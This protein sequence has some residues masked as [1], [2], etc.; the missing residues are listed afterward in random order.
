VT[1]AY[2]RLVDALGDRVGQA[3]GTKARARCP[4]HDGQSKTSLAITAIEG[5]VLLYCHAGCSTDDV[6]AALNFTKADLFDNPRG[7]TFTY[8]NGRTVKRYHRNGTKQFT[9]A[10]TAAAPEL[11]RLAKVKEAVADHR[12]VFVVEGEKDVHALESVGVVATCN[13]MGAGKWDKVDPSPLYGGKILVIAD[14]DE[15]GRRHACDV[16]A[17]LAGKAAAGIFNPATGCHDASDHI[18][19]GYGVG[20]FIPAGSASDDLPPLVRLDE[21]LAA[22]DDDLA[23]RV[24]RLWPLG[25]RVILA[26][27]W[28]AGKTTLLGNLIRSLVDAQP[29]LGTY[30]VQPAE[31]VVLIDD[32]LDKRTLRRWLRDQAITHPE[33]VE[34]ITLR[35]NV[36]TFNIVDP[37]TR[38]RWTRHIG[39]GDVLLFDCLR[40]VLDA[41]GLDESH[42][43]GRFLVAFDALLAEAGIGEAAIAHH[44]GHAGERSRG[45][46]RLRDWPDAEWRLVRDKTKDDDESDPSA[47]RYFAA[48]GRDVDQPEQLLGYDHTTRRL[49]ITGGN[50]KDARVEALIAAVV[51]YVTANPGCSQ[52]A[53][54]TAVPG[55]AQDI[56]AARDRAADRRLID[57]RKD[58]KRHSHHPCSST[59]PNSSG[60]TDEPSPSPRPLVL[61]EDEDERRRNADTVKIN[62]P[63]EDEQLDA[64]AVALLSAELGAEAIT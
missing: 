28:K 64:A 26:A 38:S 22:P 60:R 19:A 7:I 24:D 47:A 18:A 59:R 62:Q 10:N 17:S 41:L 5:A 50:R 44:M 45:D 4:A 20:D 52:N 30:D 55:R 15:P 2:D 35:G 23:Y 54:E 11:Y 3:N 32:E 63:D 53:I 1:G 57:V 42:E 8:D 29:F 51:Q 31:R 27:A 48:Y 12:P 61:Y 13:P 49:T 9:Q 6:L 16:L 46:S 25:G 21:F 43:A 58:G 56:R 40:P 39:P 37:A 14:Q 34:L 36:S 33:R